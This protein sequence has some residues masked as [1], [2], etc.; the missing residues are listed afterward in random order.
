[1]KVYHVT[2]SSDG[3]EIVDLITLN[4]NKTNS[5]SVIEVD[6]VEHMTGGI[7]VPITPRTKVVLDTMPKEEHYEFLKDL[8]NTPYDK[9]VRVYHQELPTSQELISGFNN[10]KF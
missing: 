8:R 7:I 3:V 2:P 9:S 4:V 5:L 6:G 1:M 10:R